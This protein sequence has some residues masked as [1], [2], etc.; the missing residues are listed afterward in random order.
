MVFPF[1]EIEIVEQLFSF[2][3]RFFLCHSS[4]ISRDADV[5][6]CGELG[7]EVMELEDKTDFLVTE[8]GQFGVVEFVDLSTIDEQLSTVGLVQG[9]DDVE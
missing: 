1:G 4:D 5:F 9:A 2:F 8:C 6:D 3:H 7:E